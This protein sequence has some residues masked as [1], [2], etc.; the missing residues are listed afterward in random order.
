MLCNFE[1]IF[2]KIASK[3]AQDLKENSHE[4]SWREEEKSPQKCWPNVEGAESAPP[5]A[6][7]VLGLSQCALPSAKDIMPCAGKCVNDN[8][9][10]AG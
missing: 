4:R 10:C 7:A 8:M 1:P 6:P 9:L 2:T 5:G 3:V